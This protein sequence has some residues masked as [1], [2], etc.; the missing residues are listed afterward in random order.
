[1]C[2][3]SGMIKNVLPDLRQGPARKGPAADKKASAAALPGCLGPCAERC[4][5]FFMTFVPSPTDGRLPCAG[6]GLLTGQ[7]PVGIQDPI[8]RNGAVR[9]KASV[10]T[11]LHQ[12]L[13]HAPLGCLCGIRVR[14]VCKGRGLGRLGTACGIPQQQCGLSAVLRQ[15]DVRG[16][17]G[18]A[19]SGRQ[20]GCTRRS[21]QGPPPLRR[22]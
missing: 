22:Q 6:A 1:M 4:G 17:A 2:N 5:C 21:P 7:L 20:R 18:P 12:A 3:F 14:H 15:G 11:A 16:A 10:E 9:A 19:V 13:L 8:R